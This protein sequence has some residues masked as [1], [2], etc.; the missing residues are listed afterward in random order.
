MDK[1]KIIA[2]A[3]ISAMFFGFSYFNSK[4][5]EKYNAQKAAYEAQIA[6]LKLAEEAEAAHEANR[7]EQQRRSRSVATI[8]QRLTNAKNATSRTITMENDLMKVEFSSRGGQIK[9]VTLK[10][11]TKFAEDSEQRTELVKMFE[12]ANAKT[13]LEFYIRNSSGNNVKVNT[14][15]Y[16]FNVE[17]RRRVEG[18]EE[19]TMSLSL[20]SGARLRYVYTL[21]NTQD[22]ARDYLVDLRIERD[23][24]DDILAN[25]PA[26]ILEWANRSFQNERGFTNE[27]NYT[28]VAYHLVG[29]S[30]VEELSMGDKNQS[31][32]VEKSVDWVAF[33]QQY[34]SSILIAKGGEKFSSA[35]VSY[36]TEA[37]GSGF[38]KSFSAKLALPLS[39]EST[40]YD[41]ALYFGPNSYSTLN[42]LNTIVAFE[43][44]DG[45]VAATAFEKLIPLGWGIFG[46]VNKFLVIPIFNILRGFD[47]NFG[48]IILILAI[49]VKLVIFPMTYSSYVS[50]AKMRLVKPQIEALNEKYPKP[51]DAQK[52]QQ[53]TMELYRKTGINPLGGCLPMLIQ[54]PIIIAMFRFF[55]ASIELRG[56]S[57]L[58]A[59]DLSSYDSVLNLPFNIPFYGDHV[60]LWALLMAVV[61]YFYSKMN[62]EQSSSGQPQMAGMKFMMLY[63]MPIMMLSWFNSYSSGLCYYYFLFN[64]LTIAQTVIIR[65][66]VDDEKIEAILRANV[67]KNK[68]KK[69]SNFQLRYEEALAAQERENAKKK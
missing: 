4:Q 41:L 35:D 23:N 64:I 2:L 55:P 22:E 14:S 6:E 48:L 65:K 59:N 15:Q 56:E 57:F 37:P 12:R 21:Y 18:G 54:M 34:F 44:K 69:K 11:Y 50:M 61:M 46:W 8:G 25:Q 43:D 9:G 10:D 38:I 33:K 13:D 62:Y 52:K 60:S 32:E 7:S 24:M 36:T 5:Q 49:F 29:E 66:F 39:P 45:E 51:A 40:S 28:T 16:T 63:M 1:N 68:D 67:T 58:W 42:E 31:E 53:A 30:G 47:L 3:L 26:M 17:P 20:D 27:N 19:L